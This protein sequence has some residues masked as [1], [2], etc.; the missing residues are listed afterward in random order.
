MYIYSNKHKLNGRLC[1]NVSA[2]LS[3]LRVSPCSPKQF[4]K[5][6]EKS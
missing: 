3:N 5:S 4:Y 1:G 2:W 6:S